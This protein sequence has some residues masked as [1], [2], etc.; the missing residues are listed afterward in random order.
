MARKKLKAK[1]VK[2]NY[3]VLFATIVLGF[4]VGLLTGAS[5]IPHHEKGADGEEVAQDI[6]TPVDKSYTEVPK[7]IKLR[8]HRPPA[9]FDQIFFEK[10][11]ETFMGLKILD[12]VSKEKFALIQK[13]LKERSI[14]EEDGYFIFR[15]NPQ[16]IEAGLYER[17]H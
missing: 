9:L 10:D 16:E 4:S 1:S 14:G 11:N 3:K 6:Y 8:G 15:A 12:S 17:K 7:P 5:F 13:T 2:F